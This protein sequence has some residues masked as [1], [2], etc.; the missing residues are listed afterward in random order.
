MKNAININLKDGGTIKIKGAYIYHF[1]PDKKLIGMKEIKSV[2]FAHE[3]M[4]FV[5]YLQGEHGEDAAKMKKITI[6]F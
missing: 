4:N 1:D 5:R 2:Y 6:H 3:V